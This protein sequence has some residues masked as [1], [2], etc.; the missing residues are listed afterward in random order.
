MNSFQNVGKCWYFVWSLMFLIIS[1]FIRNSDTGF[2]FHLTHEMNDEICD[3]FLF[4]IQRI[5]IKRKRDEGKGE[6]STKITNDEFP[7]QF[8]QSSRTKRSWNCLNTISGVKMVIVWCMH[9][10]HII[11]HVVR[12]VWLCLYLILRQYLW[13]Y[14]VT[15]H[16]SNGQKF[17]SRNIFTSTFIRFVWGQTQWIDLKQWTF[18]NVF[19]FIIIVKFHHSNFNVKCTVHSFP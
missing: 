9:V 3:G 17:C 7:L 15:I 16:K 5:T 18:V 8:D 12:F 4:N 10:M 1:S 13:E 14:V 2:L 19:N 11:L 6:F